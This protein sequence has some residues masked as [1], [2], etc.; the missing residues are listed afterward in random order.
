MPCVAGTRVQE[1]LLVCLLCM[2]EYS[3]EL[4]IWQT[5]EALGWCGRADTA[6]TW[7]RIYAYFLFI[8][9]TWLT[10]L[11]EALGWCGRG[12]ADTSWTEYTAMHTV[13]LF[14]WFLCLFYIPAGTVVAA[15]ENRDVRSVLSRILADS[16]AWLG[17][18]AV[19]LAHSFSSKVKIYI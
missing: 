17:V 4:T 5:T 14:A 3:D 7:S 2:N 19:M 11:E 1:P 16:S 10:W 8:C 6:C 12:R 9:L 18:I 13:W 15:G